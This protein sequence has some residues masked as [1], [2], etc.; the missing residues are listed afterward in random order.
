MLKFGLSIFLSC[1]LFSATAQTSYDVVITGG[2]VIDPE[3]GLDA[4]RNIG[5][6]DGR[7]MEI[8][9]EMLRG[10]EE[11]DASGLVVSPG[12]ID[13]HVHGT[14]NREQEYQVH[15]GVTTAL[16]LE[17]GIPDIGKWLDSRANKAL[18]NY[19]GSVNWAALRAR[20]VANMAA[21]KEQDGVRAITN[22]TTA[23]R[24]YTMNK[25]ETEALLAGLEMQ[26]KEGGI[27]FGIPVGYVPG[28]SGEEI[29]RIYELAA[30]QQVPV[31]T[32]VRKGGLPAIQQALSDAVL[33][34]ASLHIVHIN[35]MALSNIGIAIEM[36]N[37]ANSRGF[38][39]TTELYPYT[40][41]STGL[42]TALFD[43]GWQ[44]EMGITYGDI[45]WVA[46]GERL[47]E[48]TFN[49]YRKQGGTVIIHMMK[50]DWIRE[51]IR[52][53][54]TM[55]ASDGMPYAPLAHPRTAGTF[56][57]LLGK[58]VREQQLIS[59]PEALAKITLLPAKRL[60]GVAPVMRFKG[61]IQVGMD[62]DL[63]IFDPAAII[64]KAT[65]EE[66]LAFSV[67]VHH[68]LVSGQPVIRDGSLVENVFP[69]KPVYGKFKN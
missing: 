6:E 54:N 60:E 1:S 59:L 38:D 67:G 12:F 45:Q 27:G 29:Y 23:S 63:T 48:K 19:G 9:A 32:H 51:G 47:T 53:E 10:N 49:T 15:D 34:G 20:L 62:A 25:D 55:I 24:E 2:R 11:I 30:G 7:I 5:I 14:T 52:S 17:S 39:I 8:S 3:T 68:V 18:I 65:F 16:E 57:R 66:G 37:Q 50:E 28:A 44:E 56:S 13:L 4:V 58:Y 46:T 22:L 35:S 36:V 26:L 21:K 64:D 40:A 61:R 69:G 41:A 33:T 43:A 31:F 42:G